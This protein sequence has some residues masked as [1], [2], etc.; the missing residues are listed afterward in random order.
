MLWCVNGECVHNKSNMAKMWY[1]NTICISFKILLFLFLKWEVNV[2]ILCFLITFT[3]SKW[4]MLHLYSALQFATIYIHPFTHWWQQATMQGDGLAI[5][6][7]LGFRF[8]AKDTS[9]CGQEDQTANPVISGEPA[10]L[11]EAQPPQWSVFC[12]FGWSIL[13][14]RSGVR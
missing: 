6:N 4:Y 12:G 13:D 14:W 8:L 2:D 10:L 9:T 11:P 3:T 1:S 7:N 5:R